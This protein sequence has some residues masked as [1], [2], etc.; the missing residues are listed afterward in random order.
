MTDRDTITLPR[1]V[2]KQLKEVLFLCRRN[3]FYG[4]QVIPNFWKV[5]NALEA[6]LTQALIDDYALRGR[7]ALDAALAEQEPTVKESLWA[8]AQRN[9]RITCGFVDVQFDGDGW[10]CD[11]CG[12][13][14]SA[15]FETSVKRGSSEKCY[16]ELMQR[17]AEAVRTMNERNMK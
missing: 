3:A 17:K 7:A 16:L 15:D 14:M 11:K 8:G 6:A 13:R 1:A 5:A 4:G 10:F 2:G 9:P 12:E